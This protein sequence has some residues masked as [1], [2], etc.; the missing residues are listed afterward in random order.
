VVSCLNSQKPAPAAS[1]VIAQGIN[2]YAGISSNCC[3]ISRRRRQQ[4]HAS[5]PDCGKSWRSSHLPRW[6]CIEAGSFR[7]L[8][9][10]VHDMSEKNSGSQA[11]NAFG[12]RSSQE[13]YSIVDSTLV[14]EDSGNT[15]NSTDTD[16][17]V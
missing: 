7:L 10:G 8:Q 14:V 13:D 5:F 3:L 2:S 15:D 9:T 11:L 1:P 6:K 17:D 16:V 4:C 12:S